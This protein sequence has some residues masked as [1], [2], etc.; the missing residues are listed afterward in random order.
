MNRNEKLVAARYIP[1]GSRKV[2]SRIAQ[3][4]VYLQDRPAGARPFLALGYVGHAKNAT[5]H[6]AWPTA[7]ARAQF[8]ARW[9]AQVAEGEAAHA[10][11]LAERKAYRAKKSKLE[12]GHILKSS[13]GYDQTNVDFYQV[14]KLVSET[15]VEIRPIASTTVEGDGWAGKVMPLLGEFTGSAMRKRVSGGDSIK[16]E[17]FAWAHI[18]SGAPAYA[19]GYA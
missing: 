3:A 1:A 4:V 6:H 10:K 19:S 2:A 9:F 8:I 11:A 12:L 14:T 16:I 15:M 18:W 7:E 13:W 17:S 5:F